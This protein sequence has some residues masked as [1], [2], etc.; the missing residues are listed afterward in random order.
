MERNP[1]DR[2]E[3]PGGGRGDHAAAESS[4]ADEQRQVPAEVRAA[5]M[6][7]ISN[8]AGSRYQSTG[9][10]V[11][12][13]LRLL[14]GQLGMRSSHLAHVVPEDDRYE[15][16]SSFNEAGGSE[17]PAGAQLELHKTYCSE[18][19][20]L[21]EPE[22]LIVED[23]QEDH[24][25]ASHPAPE[26]FPNIGSYLGVPVV[27]SDGS[28]Y[29]TLC[30]VDPKPRHLSEYQ[31]SL[32]LVLARIVATAIER[33]EE[34]EERKRAEEELRRQLEF[35]GAVTSS[36]HSGLFALDL[37]GRITFANP[38][39]ERM[40]G[41]GGGELLD[42]NVDEVVYHARK[43]VGPGGP[44]VTGS[45]LDKVRSEDPVRVDDDAFVRRDG[46]EFTAAYS[47]APLVEDGRVVG[48]VV[49]FQDITGRRRAEHAQRQLAAIVASSQDAI[50]GKTTDGVVTSWNRG[51]E[52][53]YGYSAEEAVGRHIS[54][55]LP[56]DYPDEVSEILKKI[57][58][59]EKVGSYETLRATK[60]GRL[61]TVS[62]TVSPV[63]DGSGEVAG[64][65]VIARDITERKKV[66]AEVVRALDA[67]RKANEK[68]ER[69]N[70]IRSDFV[71]VV[72]HEFRTALTGIQGFSQ[73]IKDEN[74]SVEEVKEF[75]SDINEDAKRLN[76]MINEM[77][78]LDRMESGRM[79]L[80]MDQ[81]DINAL[82][83]EA[84]RSAGLNAPGHQIRS[85]LDGSLPRFPGD[86]DK[87]VQVVS[88]LLS[89]AVKYSPEGGRISVSSRLEGG[90]VHL[91]VRDEGVGIS[92]EALENLFQPYS[93][94][95]SENTRYIKGTGLGLAI[96]R[97]IV[98][99]H[100][101]KIWA[102]SVVGEGSTLHVSIPLYDATPDA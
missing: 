20:R 17:V 57:R 94:V 66:E 95:E 77:L 91:R 62:L 34:I 89:N 26:A 71:S 28:L 11:E 24:R 75:A 88:N 100:G 72:S 16:V 22:P 54:F 70:K 97:E 5:Y 6:E 67:Q 39:A 59:G 43:W 58:R 2:P 93:R 21:N 90:N 47:S 84:V 33:D 98:G 49:S 9:E 102:E 30:A 80:N 79:T 41:W 56:K 61:V 15:I 87:L 44:G 38:A 46:E 83:E 96:S 18:I 73:M 8:L 40:L 32:P 64:A 19:S 1:T 82:I 86:R 48:F 10:M 4:Q 36:L 65:S 27:M 99:L 45:L 81:V 101:G 12:A 3:Q 68:L 51:A 92:P 37:E 74:L 60:D 42:R 55:L 29:G 13:V 14:V 35:T 7:S 63:R 85:Q 23:A 25:F 52:R 50:I 31:A 53:L 78:D 76:R 69:M